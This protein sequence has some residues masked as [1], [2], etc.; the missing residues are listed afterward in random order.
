MKNSI[1]ISLF[2]SFILFQNVYSQKGCISGNCED[3]FGTYLYSDGDK[4]IGKFKDGLFNGGC[5]DQPDA[6]PLSKTS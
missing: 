1:L 2:F 5:A 4:Y 6:V 3:G